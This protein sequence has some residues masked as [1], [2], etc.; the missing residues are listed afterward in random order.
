[1]EEGT[2]TDE[3]IPVVVVLGPAEVGIE[4][5]FREAGVAVIRD[6]DLPTVAALA[7]VALAFVGND[8]GVSHLAAAVGTSGVVIFGPSDPARWRP[9]ATRPGQ[10]IEIVRGDP[11]ERVDPR[12]VAGVLS[13]ICRAAANIID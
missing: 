6:L 2:A 7:R 11:I 10:R 12:E 13:K 4:T 5:I 8:S 9:I 3:R 1:M